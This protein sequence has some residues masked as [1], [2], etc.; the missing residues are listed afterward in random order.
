L[1]D[2]QI[3]VRPFAPPPPSRRIGLVWRRLSAR[4]SEYAALASHIR[5]ALSAAGADVT[6]LP[7]DAVS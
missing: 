7:A 6:A 5:D 1:N 3:V 2:S 4:G